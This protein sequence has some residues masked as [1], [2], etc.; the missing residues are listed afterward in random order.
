VDTGEL[1]GN[2]QFT[3]APEFAMVLGP[4]TIQAEW[5]GQF[6]TNA[7]DANGESQGT[8]FYH[9]GYIEALWFLTGEHREYVRRDG[10]LGRVVP[11]HNYHWKKDDC[12]KAC[13][14]W[15]IG[16][17]FSYLDLDSKSV[18][19]GN[20]YDWTLGLNWY[21]NP[22]MK[23]Q[24]NWIAEHRDMPGVTPGWINGFGARV[25]YDF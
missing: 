12:Y 13:G 25:A 22:N 6:L 20:L 3:I 15:E 7:N 18:Q 2:K 1:P 5:A 19:A 16:V 24:L 9:G 10:V 11:L 4:L 21:L 23:C 17:R 8:V 14:A